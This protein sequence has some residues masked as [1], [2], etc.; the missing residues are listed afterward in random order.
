MLFGPARREVRVHFHSLT[1]AVEHEERDPGRRPRGPSWPPRPPVAL[2]RCRRCDSLC[3]GLRS[4][5]IASLLSAHG[6]A[7]ADHGVEA[8]GADVGAVIIGA[9]GSAGIAGGVQAGV[10]ATGGV[11]CTGVDAGGVQ[12]GVD[13]IGEVVWAGVDAGAVR[14]GL[15]GLGAEAAGTG[16]VAIGAVGGLALRTTLVNWLVA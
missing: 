16:G 10:A 4:A 12:A 9:T 14:A 6:A 5:G 11:D 7:G 8:E 1:G 2:V 3:A 13:G 15:A